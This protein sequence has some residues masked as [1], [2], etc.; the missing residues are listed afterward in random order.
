M[1]Y[2]C[3]S[4]QNEFTHITSN[5]PNLNALSEIHSTLLYLTPKNKKFEG[6]FLKL[7]N[8]S[9]T[10]TL[11]GYGYNTNYVALDVKEVYCENVVPFYGKKQHITLAIKES[12]LSKNSITCFTNK[13]SKYVAFE[14]P[15]IVQGVILKINKSLSSSSLIP[16]TQSLLQN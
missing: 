15:L 7:E 6:Q 3:A 12:K 2:W 5:F 11:L 4:L 10:I 14:E 1:S 9:C 8:Q 16:I 13:T